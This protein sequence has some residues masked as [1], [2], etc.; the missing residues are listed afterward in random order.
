MEILYVRIGRLFFNVCLDNLGFQRFGEEVT[1]E[2]DLASFCDELCSDMATVVQTVSNANTQGSRDVTRLMKEKEKA[3]QKKQKEQDKKDTCDGANTRIMAFRKYLENLNAIMEE[4]HELFRKAEWDLIEARNVLKKM[5]EHMKEQKRL[6]QDALNEL[7]QAENSA[8]EKL[9]IAQQSLED[10]SAE[11]EK[12]TDTWNSLTADLVMVQAAERHFDEVKQRLSKLLLHMDG[13]AEECVREP[14]RNIGLSEET[15]VYDGNFFKPNVEDLQ[16]HEEMK[17][18]LDAFHIYCE[19]IAK[20][21]FARVTNIDL[22]PLCDLGD[23][24]QTMAE[25]AGAVQKRKDLVVKSIQDVQSWLDPFKGTLVTSANEES[26]YVEEGEPLGLRRVVG[27]MSQGNQNNF[28]SNYLKKWKKKGEFQAL[29]VTIGQ[30][31]VDLDEKVNTAASEMARLANKGKAAQ[32]EF[33][34]AT[35]A[36]QEAAQSLVAQKETAQQISQELDDQV[37]QQRQTLEDLER[38]VK[39]AAEAWKL[40][41]NNLLAGH[42]TETSSLSENHA[43]IE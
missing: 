38:K 5:T 8:K 6:M 29:L 24:K 25:I 22:S 15:H 1:A 2:E 11:L 16:A 10:T 41:K 7:G 36:F 30:K 43:A 35:A 33:E 39:E 13:F 4:K 32:T 21:V 26:D 37:A 17:A 14:V 40:A 12:V 20:D 19:T 18:Q 34:E 27:P 42:Q 31:V 3:L 23:K 28:Y 9:E